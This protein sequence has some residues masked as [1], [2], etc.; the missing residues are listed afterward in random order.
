M[1]IAEYLI[2]ENL[3]LETPIYQVALYGLLIVAL[4]VQLC[5]YLSVFRG[6]TRCSKSQDKPIVQQPISIVIYAKNEAQSLDAHLPFFLEQNYPHFEVIVV[7]DSSTDNTEELLSN[8]KLKYPHLHYSN[9]EFNEKFKHDRK[10]G[11]IVGMKAAQNDTVI[12]TDADC[13]P[14]DKHW[15]ATMQASFTDEKDFVIGHCNYEKLNKWMRCDAIYTALFSIH[16]ARRG[17]PIKAT[18]KNLGLRK[19]TFFANNGFAYINHLPNS[20][21]TLFVSRNTNAKNTVVAAFPNSII[22]STQRLKFHQWWKERVTQS[23]LFALNKRSHIVSHIEMISRV[24]YYI[25][26]V[27]LLACAYVEHS[28]LIIAMVAPFVL[29]RWI[30]QL[31]LFSRIK[32]AWRGHGMVLSLFFYDRLSPWLALLIALCCPNLHKNKSAI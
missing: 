32:K 3:F 1:N 27:A 20:E 14:F 4:I 11:I 2:F 28:A 24:A 31:G 19:K 21:E 9:I 23:A 18:F 29:L 7:N 12:F 5:Y 10:L 16:A 13:V 17:K 30:L 15:L 25:A 26:A 6:A 22:S 8:L